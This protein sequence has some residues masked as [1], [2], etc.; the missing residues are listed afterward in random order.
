MAN[1]ER[2]KSFRNTYFDECI[3]RNNLD[4]R[5]PASYIINQAIGAYYATNDRG[6]EVFAVEDMPFSHT[7][8]EFTKVL[9]K[10]GIEEFY[11]FD[12]SSDGI[13]CLH[14]LL[15]LGWKVA[16]TVEKQINS[17]TI[18]YG[19]VMRKDNALEVA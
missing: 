2:M 4:L 1:V 16:G 10:A 18:I 17:F 7:M 15:E 3:A 9:E 11:L 8:S 14:H 12:R 13:T 6:F 19:V 5:D